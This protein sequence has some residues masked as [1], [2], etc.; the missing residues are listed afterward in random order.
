MVETRPDSGLRCYTRPHDDLT[1]GTGK[2]SD[3]K[4]CFW[5]NQLLTVMGNTK[6]LANSQSLLETLQS[7][8]GSGY[9]G[10]EYIARY[11]WGM[12]SP[13]TIM[14]EQNSITNDASVD[15]FDRALQAKWDAAGK[16]AAA[17][18]AS[19]F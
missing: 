15:Y 2:L 9:Q 11:I 12:S 1:V 17:K 8:Y 4:Y 5:N 13:I 14:Y 18:S 19:Q 3:L 16:N 10:N 7:K 6:G